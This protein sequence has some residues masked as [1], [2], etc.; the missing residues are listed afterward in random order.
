M[1][2]ALSCMGVLWL[3]KTVKNH[4]ISLIFT[5]MLIKPLKRVS[6]RHMA[7]ILNVYGKVNFLRERYYKAVAGKSALVQ[8]IG[9]RRLPSR[10][11]IPTPL[12][13]ALLVLR[14][15]KRYFFR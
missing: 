3:G 7:K 15:P 5:F 12:K 4:K 8:M 2:D 11:I 9:R 14:K 13:I 1:T 10:F 6:L